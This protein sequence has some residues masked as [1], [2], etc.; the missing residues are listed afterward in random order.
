MISKVNYP[1]PLLFLAMMLCTISSWG[2]NPT[3]NIVHWTSE[4]P[5]EL[6]MYI[7]E[8]P[9]AHI[10]LDCDLDGH[11]VRFESFDGNNPAID[12]AFTGT[13]D[14][15]GHTI[16]NILCTHSWGLFTRLWG[17]TVKNL[18][19]EGAAFDA[20]NE[21]SVF[22]GVAR[23]MRNSTVEN[24]TLLNCKVNSKE[25][26]GGI[27]GKALGHYNDL[28]DVCRITNCKIIN[29]E[30]TSCDDYYAGGIVGYAEDCVITDCEFSGKV[31]AKEYT[32]GIVGYYKGKNGNGTIS[33]CT[34][35]ADVTSTKYDAAG[36]VAGYVEKCEI[37]SCTVNGTIKA[38][39]K[40]NSDSNCGGIVGQACYYVK[41]DKCRNEAKV[42]ATGDN[43]GGIVGY[44]ERKDKNIL[45]Y[46]LNCVNNGPI[47]PTTNSGS[48]DYAGGI[49]GRA[50]GVQIMN[51]TN[52]GSVHVQDTRAGGIAGIA[53]NCYIF[54]NHN[55]GHIIANGIVGGLIG[56]L[57]KSDCSFNFSEGTLSAPDPT[58]WSNH[59]KGALFG[60][61]SDNRSMKSNLYMANTGVPEKKDGYRT[62]EEVKSG[63]V[64]L[65]LQTASGMGVWGQKMNMDGSNIDFGPTLFSPAVFK[66]RETCMGSVGH[67]WYNNH[68]SYHLGPLLPTT[69]TIFCEACRSYV[70][71]DSDDRCYVINGVHD[72]IEFKA[73]VEG[74]T[75]Y[76][77]TEYLTPTPNAHAVLGCD[78][79]MYGGDWEPLGTKEVPFVGTFDGNGHTINNFK[80]K[81][82][83]FSNV[84]FFG[85]ISDGAVIKNLIIGPNVSFSGSPLY[86]GGIA[87]CIVD[88]ASTP[89]E[90]KVE[91]TNC[92][93]EASLSSQGWVGG[94]VGGVNAPNYYPIFSVSITNCYN[95][96]TINSTTNAASIICV[97]SPQTVVKNCWNAGAGTT[98]TVS[99]PQNPQVENNWDNTA[100]P[101]LFTNEDVK[102]G[103]LC[104]LLNGSQNSREYPNSSGWYQKIGTDMRPV[105]TQGEDKIVYRHNTYY[106]H[107]TDSVLTVYNNTADDLPP[108]HNYDEKGFCYKV[109]GEV[110]YEEPEVIEGVYQIKNAGNLYW[111]AQQVNNLEINHISCSILNDIVDNDN[112]LVNGALDQST[113]S[114]LRVW[115]PIG[116]D[117]VSLDAAHIRGNGHTI[118][119]LYCNNESLNCVGLF[120]HTGNLTAIYD[121]GVTD[122]YFKGKYNVGGIVGM[123]TT[124]D[125]VY[126]STGTILHNCYTDNG[127]VFATGY[128]GGIAGYNNHGSQRTEIRQRLQNLFSTCDVTANHNQGAVFGSL[129]IAPAATTLLPTCYSYKGSDR[130]SATRQAKEFCLGTLTF[131]LNSNISTEGDL[132]GHHQWGQNLATDSIPSFKYNGV[133]YEV[134][135]ENSWGNVMLPFAVE[136]NDAV[137]FLKLKKASPRVPDVSP[138]TLVYSRIPGVDA[139]KPVVYHMLDNDSTTS[140]KTLFLEAKN[141]YALP[142]STKYS[143]VTGV[144]GWVLSGSY[145]KTRVYDSYCIS[146]EIYMIMPG[147]LI[148]R[149][150]CWMTGDPVGPGYRLTIFSPAMGDVNEDGSVDI[151]DVAALVDKMMGEDPSPFNFDCA[152]MNGDGVIDIDDVNRIIEIILAN[153]NKANSRKK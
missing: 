73:Y 87:G 16:R 140:S 6:G 88:P 109:P 99:V 103:R 46:V 101:E 24:V 113:V 115:T 144:S 92:G 57:S 150:G 129:G 64:A 5:E 30:I 68:A 86:M 9:D 56:D 137:E 42:T 62:Q 135:T 83:T 134:T 147:W 91:I 114:K 82:E 75:S 20:D 153:A 41:V 90:L 22:G 116:N 136:S 85:C 125:D 94:I 117:N 77:G 31:N 106:C 28:G 48:S 63:Q 52:I 80:V 89:K 81:G 96:G 27:A 61:E 32:G 43:T 53:V 148:P 72:L 71:F 19:I 38:D 25:Y 49:V 124:T 2:I 79:D 51:N 67:D 13:F 122:F 142:D 123:G 132:Y 10:V 33:N 118:S 39:N 11:G 143:D 141:E 23:E 66:H 7:L 93:N 127:Q 138:A 36:G 76:W 12:Y 21:D 149:F 60:C 100:N 45:I 107:N 119:G 126:E 18:T 59:T 130:Y 29:A 102:S 70:R 58:F 34:V 112:V 97:G 1:K 84:G 121:L 44:C 128:A 17:A 4:K 95:L 145:N 55:K 26:T 65:E 152:D 15:N 74:G 78:I 111:I 37:I 105:W 110:H 14:G 146:E 50:D 151:S 139:N 69:Q 108:S 47:S 35:N 8:H 104:W 131:E 120:G 98:H 54:N 40:F 133:Y 3:S